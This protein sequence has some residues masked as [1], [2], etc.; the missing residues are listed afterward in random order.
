MC[1]SLPSSPPLCLI[2]S[3]VKNCVSDIGFNIVHDSERLRPNRRI[4]VTFFN[5]KY[6]RY[7][8]IASEVFSLNMSMTS[9]FVCNT[10]FDSRLLNSFHHLADS[11]LIRFG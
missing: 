11:R 2:E 8:L 3:E 5:Y 1:S 9:D 7:V 6:I 10:F 4:Q